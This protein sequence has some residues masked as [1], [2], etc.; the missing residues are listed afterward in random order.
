VKIVEG[1]LIALDRLG[2]KLVLSTF[3]IARWISLF[4]VERVG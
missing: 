4:V 1:L 2:L 3:S